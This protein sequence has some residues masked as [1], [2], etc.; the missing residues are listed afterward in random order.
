MI[1]YSISLFNYRFMDPLGNGD[2]PKTMRGLVRTRLP[3]FTKEQSKLVS[4]SFDFI[5]INYYSSCY[6]S[7]APQLSNGKPS[8]L[9]DSLSRFSCKHPFGLLLS[10][11]YQLIKNL[12]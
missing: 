8:Y 9:T 4:G 3:K 7:D 2:Y 11:L 1:T 5:G 10:I 6:A 12:N